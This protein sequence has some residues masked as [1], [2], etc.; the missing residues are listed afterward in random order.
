[1]HFILR[2]RSPTRFTLPWAP[3]LSLGVLLL[4]LVVLDRAAH[5]R[6]GSV[7]DRSLLLIHDDKTPAADAPG[8]PIRVA[9]RADGHGELARI[10]LE[11]KSIGR[12]DAAFER[13]GR[14][15][16]RLVHRAGTPLPEDITL[17]IDADSD[18]QYKHVLRAVS[19]CTGQFDPQTG[20]LVR[21]VETI[22]FARRD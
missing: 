7:S 18:L 6:A 14:E 11:H 15:I 21:A 1:M 19:A 5:W 20:A 17:E 9:L 13:L 8:S 2:D 22:T 12:D 16:R 3:L 4:P 10:E